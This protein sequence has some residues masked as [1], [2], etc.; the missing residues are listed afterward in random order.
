MQRTDLNTGKIIEAD[1]EFPSGIKTN[2]EETDEEE[3]L[4]EMTAIINENMANFQRGG[5]N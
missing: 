5:S 1:A 3:L 2:V 4:N